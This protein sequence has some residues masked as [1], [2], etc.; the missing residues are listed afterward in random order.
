MTCILGACILGVCILETTL[1]ARASRPLGVA[2][3]KAGSTVQ[4]AGGTP[5]LPG[6]PGPRP[7]RS[8]TEMVTVQPGADIPGRLSLNL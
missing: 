5:A 7:Q 8:Q 4:R 1:G 3:G 6:S 2:S